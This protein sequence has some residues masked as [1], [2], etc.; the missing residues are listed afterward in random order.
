MIMPKVQSFSWPK[1]AAGMSDNPT[2]RVERF[3]C[4]SS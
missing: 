1:D 2:A 3:L 4:G